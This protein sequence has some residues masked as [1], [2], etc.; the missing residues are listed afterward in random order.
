MKLS[1]KEMFRLAQKK[2]KKNVTVK[3]NF[4]SEIEWKIKYISFSLFRKNDQII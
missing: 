1:S 3:C 4:I 2:K